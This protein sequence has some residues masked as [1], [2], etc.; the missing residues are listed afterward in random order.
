MLAGTSARRAPSMCYRLTG[1]IR[2]ISIVALLGWA[3]LLQPPALSQEA[4]CLRRTLPLTV[5]DS[6]GVPIEGLGATDFEARF[7]AGPVKILSIVPDDRP[8]RIVILVDASAT[9]ATKWREVLAPASD[10]AETSLPNTR[11]ALIV[12]K[13]KIEEQIN[14]SDGQSAVAERL[15][16]MRSTVMSRQTTGG[17][18]AIFDS[19]LAG[20][21]LLETPTSADSLYLVSDGAD[22]ASH[23]HLDDIA[24]TLSNNGVRVFVSLILGHLGQRSATPEEQGGPF[25]MNELAKKTG[26]LLNTP[27]GQGIPTKPQQAERLSQTMHK[28]YQAMAQNYRL[29]LELPTA[30]EKPTTWELKL[31]DQGA[32]HGR[33]ETLTLTYPTQLAPCK[34]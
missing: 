28:F 11:M 27:F 5:A 16:Q 25:D 32:M 26:G 14:F 20:L 15:R 1:M 33:N 30:L 29:E 22:N 10:L 2:P 19:L 21:R 17:R 13:H 24:Q 8:H 18:T 3:A 6:Q 12:F 34:R 7:R 23:A 4:T 9:M 31:S